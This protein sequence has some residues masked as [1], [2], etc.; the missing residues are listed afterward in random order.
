[1]KIIQKTES[2]LLSRTQ[3]LASLDHIGKSTPSEKEVTKLI[4][5]EMKVKEE[6]IKIKNIFSRF[7]T[8]KSRITAYIYKTKKD[9]DETEPQIRK[10]ETSKQEAQAEE[11]K[12]N[13]KEERKA[14]EAS[15][16]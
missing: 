8:G 2:P 15:K 5:D 3:I 12:E 7:G 14:K 11:P 10:K 16:K 6:V 4:A 9:L 1:M 13:G